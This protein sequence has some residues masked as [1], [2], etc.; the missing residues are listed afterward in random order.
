MQTVTE[1]TPILQPPREHPASPQPLHPCPLLNSRDQD[2]N[3][4]KIKSSISTSLWIANMQLQ[5]IKSWD[6]AF[7]VT[8]SKCCSINS[9]TES[10]AGPKAEPH[11]CTTAPWGQTDL[12]KT[13]LQQG[14]AV[15]LSQSE[16]HFIE[17][18][19]PLW[20]VKQKAAKW[21]EALEYK[22]LHHSQQWEESLKKML[23]SDN[24]LLMHKL[25]HTDWGMCWM[26]PQ[27]VQTHTEM[28]GWSCMCTMPMTG[29]KYP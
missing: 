21:P 23:Y 18:T 27:Q 26:Q 5:H 4:L 10:W 25:C 8:T 1:S 29:K 14:M 28:L 15:P 7:P 6:P 11:N 3:H 9:N 17:K 2:P 13:I 24:P 22:Q 12:S 20:Q 16:K 19:N